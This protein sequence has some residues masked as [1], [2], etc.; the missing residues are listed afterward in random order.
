MTVEV[1]RLCLNLLRFCGGCSVDCRFQKLKYIVIM[2]SN[3]ILLTVKPTRK[4]LTVKLTSKLALNIELQRCNYYVPPLS[5]QWV[6]RR[7]K[8]SLE[9]IRLPHLKEPTGRRKNHLC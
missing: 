6:L 8:L 5:S 3:V 2:F 1:E 9:M 7:V 4:K